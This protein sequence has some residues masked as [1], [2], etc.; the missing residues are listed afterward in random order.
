ML[1]R[2]ILKSSAV[3]AL[4][5]VALLGGFP[6]QE[7]VAQTQAYRIE[8]LGPNLIE[9]AKKQNP[10]LDNGQAYDAAVKYAGERFEQAE[11]DSK[12]KFPVFVLYY[13]SNAQQ[14]KPLNDVY[15]RMTRAVL[16]DKGYK[17]TVLVV[18]QYKYPHLTR[19]NLFKLPIGVDIAVTPFATALIDGEQIK[20]DGMVTTVKTGVESQG[21][22]YQVEMHLK[23]VAIQGEATDR[24]FVLDLSRSLGSLYNAADSEFLLR[25]PPR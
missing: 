1:R 11:A 15:L 14:K 4:V 8:H 19:G 17:G 3:S 13:N 12:S 25:H 16:N 2:A 5:G 18:D 20:G 22:T 23:G 10:A 6:I 24:A 21:K 7:A 9:Q